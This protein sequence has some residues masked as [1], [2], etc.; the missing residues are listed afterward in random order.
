MAIALLM[1][2]RHT[3]Q[4]IELAPQLLD[5]SFQRRVLLP[6][7]RTFL[8]DSLHLLAL[9]RAALRCCDFVLLAVPL[10]ALCCAGVGFGGSF[11]L[12]AVVPRFLGFA[13]ALVGGVAGAAG[14]V[15]FTFGWRGG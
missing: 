7:P 4:L 10:F 2:K 6:Q 8:L 15:A 3:P 13:V 11:V 9:P 14:F 12:R 5:H 1:R